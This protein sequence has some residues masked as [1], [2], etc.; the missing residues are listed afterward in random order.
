MMKLLAILIAFA[1]ACHAEESPISLKDLGDAVGYPSS[2]LFVR[3]VTAANEEARKTDLIAVYRIDGKPLGSF[4]PVYV[5]VSKAGVLYNEEVKAT[6]S[7]FDSLPPGPRT[8]LGQRGILGSFKTEDGNT[9]IISLGSIKIPAA[10]F[11]LSPEGEPINQ[12]ERP[13]WVKDEVGIYVMLNLPGIDRDIQIFFVDSSRV[14]DPLLKIEGGEKYWNWI[15][16]EGKKRKTPYDETPPVTEEENQL[17][18]TILQAATNAVVKSPLLRTTGSHPP[19]RPDAKRVETQSEGVPDQH[20][21]QQPKTNDAD[22]D[23]SNPKRNVWWFVAAI[24]L[25]LAVGAGAILHRRNAPR[26]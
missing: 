24:V 3:D 14:S 25:A 21:P 7:K 20:T 1:V 18:R 8:D 4:L 22:K 10:E 2:S 17:A 15:E 6:A 23:Q 11:R 19:D 5:Y 13:G 12:Q 16:R 9:G 26:S